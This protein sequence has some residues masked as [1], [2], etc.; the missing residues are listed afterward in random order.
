GRDAF[1][2]TDVVGITLPITKHSCLVA[3]VTELADR[4][5]EAIAIAREGR[6]GPVVIDVPKDVQNQKAEYREPEARLTPGASQGASSATASRATPRALPRAPG[7][8]TWIW[9]RRKSAR[10]YR[11]RWRWWAMRAA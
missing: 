8:C 1:Q 7:S 5:R 11:S 6:P 4:M 3:D 9:T 2:E 10:T